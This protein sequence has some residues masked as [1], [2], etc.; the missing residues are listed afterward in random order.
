M[1]KREIK[2]I[3]QEKL[4]EIIEQDSKFN[5]SIK[6]P[7]GVSNH[8]VHLT[9]IAVERL[10][11]KGHQ[12]TFLKDLSQPGQYACQETLTVI[13]PKGKLKNVRVLGPIRKETQ[14]EVSLTDGMRIGVSPPV[15]MSGDI[16]ESVPFTLQGPRGQ[17]NFDEGLICASRHIHMHPEEAK[18]IEVKNGEKVD[19]L[20]SGNRSVT[21]HNVVIRISS[22]FTLEMHIDFDEAN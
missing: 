1:E 15:R 12:L 16:A 9:E 7:I 17:M 3:V 6:V 21:F 13:G 5:K 10:F 18:K 20:V 8:H 2:T 22:N 19:I 14:V 4:S 11:G